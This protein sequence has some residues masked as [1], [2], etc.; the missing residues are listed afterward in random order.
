ML[1]RIVEQEEAVQTALRLLNKNDL[2]ISNEEVDVIKGIIELL[3]PFEAVTREILAESYISGSKIIPLS[4]ALQRLTCS[5]KKLE[6]QKLRNSFLSRMNR[7]FLILRT[8][9]YLLSQHCWILDLKI[10]IFRFWSCSKG[11]TVHH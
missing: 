1:E 8:I 4:R 2:T 10:S 3:Q 11:W 9:C 5:A 7:K 6:V